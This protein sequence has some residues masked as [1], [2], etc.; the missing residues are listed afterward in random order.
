MKPLPNSIILRRSSGQGRCHETSSSV[1]ELTKVGWNNNTL[2][3]TEPATLVY[4]QLTFTPKTGS[5]IR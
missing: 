1:L 5:R 2:Y 3:K 4:S